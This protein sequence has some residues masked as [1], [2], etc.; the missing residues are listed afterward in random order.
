MDG[1]SRTPLLYF[2]VS[3]RARTLLFL[4]LLAVILFLVRCS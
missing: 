2:F 3:D 1:K 4:L